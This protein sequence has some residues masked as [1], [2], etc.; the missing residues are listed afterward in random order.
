MVERASPGFYG[1][2][3]FEPNLQSGSGIL[4]GDIRNLDP[5]NFTPPP[6]Q[7]FTEISPK[8]VIFRKNF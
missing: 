2:S 8:M 3:T 6:A 7:V 5:E 4:L 1:K